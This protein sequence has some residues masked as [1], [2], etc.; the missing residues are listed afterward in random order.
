MLPS[1]TTSATTRRKDVKGRHSVYSNFPGLI[2]AF[3]PPGLIFTFKT[4]LSFFACMVLDVYIKIC[5]LL[6]T[7][8]FYIYYR[9]LFM[10]AYKFKYKMLYTYDVNIRK[11]IFLNVVQTD[12][13][14][15]SSQ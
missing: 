9:C 15:S 1:L 5:L 3:L 14:C 8:S 4:S 13:V 10:P 7:V 12:T 11:R 6:L 2:L